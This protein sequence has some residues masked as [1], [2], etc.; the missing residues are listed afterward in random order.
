MPGQ[1]EGRPS[2]CGVGHD[3]ITY[4]TLKINHIHYIYTPNSLVL[5]AVQ[6]TVVKGSDYEVDILYTL[7]NAPQN[8]N[9]S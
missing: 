9:K 7:F 1:S 3:V 5:L 6:I 4:H 2:T 8:I